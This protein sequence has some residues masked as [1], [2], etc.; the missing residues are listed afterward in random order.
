MRCSVAVGATL[1]TW[2]RGAITF[3]APPLQAART[4]QSVKTAECWKNRVAG[5]FRF[6]I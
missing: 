5:P 4:A 6:D 1:A 2:A 3:E